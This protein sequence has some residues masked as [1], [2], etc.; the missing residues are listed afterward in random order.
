MIYQGHIEKGMV[1]FNEPVPLADGKAVRVE[2]VGSMASDF[3]QSLSLD[4]LASRQGVDP[5]KSE[6]ELFDQTHRT[7]GS[8][9]D[10][11]AVRL[12]SI[13]CRRGEVPHLLALA[14]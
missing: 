5:P 6:D 2:P 7:R 14:L 3:W 11:T 1:I 9:R 4:E 8:G 10:A 12:T 13:C